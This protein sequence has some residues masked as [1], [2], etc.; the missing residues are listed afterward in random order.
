MQTIRRTI[1]PVVR[2]VDQAR[3]IVDYIAS[4]ETIDSYR[5]IVRADGW[6][7]THFQ[8]N[9]PFVDSHSYD[10]IDKLLGRVIDFR[11][12]NRQLIERVQWAIDVP[13]NDLAQLGWKMTV[14]GYLKAVSVGFAPIR[15]VSKYGDASLFEREL[16]Q[17]NLPKE[18]ASRVQVIYLEHE[19]IELSAC[20]IGANPNALAKAQRDGLLSARD[21]RCLQRSES[22]A[23]GLD[24][25]MR[26]P[27]SNP[28]STRDF[29]RSLKQ[30][31]GALVA[32]A[33]RRR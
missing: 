7:F 18:E 27:R 10:S 33:A 13:E 31:R 28:D 19:Q 32:R 6:R 17:F 21:L 15:T 4:D 11:V 14:G 3:G 26:E 8:K 25:A 23:R 29:L 16:S 1:N 20:V 9:A 12:S 2:I 5:E 22:F 30:L 24:A